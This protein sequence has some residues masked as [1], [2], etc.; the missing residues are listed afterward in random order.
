M[1]MID[2]IL[3]EFDSEFGMIFLAFAQIMGHKTQ[4]GSASM[5]LELTEENKPLVM[6][7][8]GEWLKDQLTKYG[9]AVKDGTR[10]EAIQK[11][12]H[13]LDKHRFDQHHHII[14]C[15]YCLLEKEPSSNKDNQ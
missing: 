6:K 11:Y 14:N 4:T 13:H 9:Q 2:K 15:I 1:N 10:K 3:Q 12:R 8:I 5:F 7:E